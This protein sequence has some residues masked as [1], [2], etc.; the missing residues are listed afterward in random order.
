MPNGIL[1]HLNPEMRRAEQGGGAGEEGLSGE[2]EGRYP[3]RGRHG[4]SGNE[5]PPLITTQGED[6]TR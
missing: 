5:A 3:R 4:A 6:V 2:R 1:A